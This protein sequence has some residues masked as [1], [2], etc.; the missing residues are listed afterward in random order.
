MYKAVS[1]LASA[2]ILCLSAMLMR[3]GAIINLNLLTLYGVIII[4]KEEREQNDSII[5]TLVDEAH[6]SWCF[7]IFIL[8]F[9]LKFFKQIY[10]KLI[11]FTFFA[12]LIVL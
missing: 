10:K 9:Y 1:A 4:S 8:T 11:K 6:A 5:V 12:I 2:V 7:S 3:M